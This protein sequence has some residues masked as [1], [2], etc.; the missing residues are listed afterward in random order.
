M[1]LDLSQYEP[2]LMALGIG[3]YAGTGAPSFAAKQGSLYIRTDGSSTSTRMYVNT[4][5]STTW[6]NFTTAA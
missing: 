2:A 5:G 6:T 3:F 4:D 1:T